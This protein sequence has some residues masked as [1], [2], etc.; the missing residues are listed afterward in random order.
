MFAARRAVTRILM[1]VVL[2]IALEDALLTANANAARPILGMRLS[3]RLIHAAGAQLDARIEQLA[4]LM[5]SYQ[6]R[7]Y[8]VAPEAVG[9]R[10]DL[11]YVRYE[12]L[13]PGHTG[14]F[15]ARLIAQHR[16]LMGLINVAASGLIS[17][18]KLAAAT[19]ALNQQITQ[20]PL[21]PM[22]D[23]SHDAGVVLPGKDGVML[24][25][26]QAQN[27]IIAHIFN[28]PPE[29][30]P[31]P[32]LA[33]KAVYPDLEKELA[34]IAVEAKRL[35]QAPISIKSGVDTL[36]FSPRDLRLM[37]TVV[38]RPD[39]RDPNKSHLELRLDAVKLNQ[40]LGDFA[41]LV[42]SKTQAEFDDHD[43][44]IAVYAQ[45][46]SGMRKTIEVPTGN[47]VGLRK[48]LALAPPVDMR[49]AAVQ[50]AAA[51]NALPITGNKIV[52]LTFDDGPNNLYH[53]IVLQILKKYG[54]KATFFLVGQNVERYPDVALQT[55]ADGHEVGDHSLTHAFLPKLGLPAINH[56]V[57]STTSILEKL[58]H[59]KTTL[60]RPP[61]GGVDEDVRVGAK[62]LDL[63]LV[64]W[65]VDPRDWS[66]PTTDKLIH[67]VVD[68]VRPG[69]DILMH[70]NHQAT[71]NALPA[72]IEKLQ[73]KGYVFKM[74]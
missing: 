8:T 6:G 56:E 67:R 1:V 63:K 31:A 2:F 11:S 3:G 36:T 46:F 47:E 45:F 18:D 60:F 42:E 15:F 20:D 68:Y 71:V 21:P 59:Q 44:R 16:A 58:L 9:A 55:F 4:P 5:F 53:P 25:A 28:P 74:L 43:A 35:T 29:P 69:A 50:T 34:G 66:E 49:A 19:E 52:Y 72:I 37:L 23:F 17:K 65:D 24:D 32:T 12:L 10:V 40:R 54:V 70:S 61:Y 41:A 64:L 38:A 33:V 48:E 62:R 7:E 27:M 30:L 26:A 14:T 73:A 13:A 22:P 39:T 57:A 51:A